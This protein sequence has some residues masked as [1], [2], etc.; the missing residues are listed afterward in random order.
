MKC[1]CCCYLEAWVGAGVLGGLLGE[2]L[3]MRRLEVVLVKGWVGILQA[4]AQDVP[5]GHY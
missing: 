3:E 5:C 4:A 1:G 2:E